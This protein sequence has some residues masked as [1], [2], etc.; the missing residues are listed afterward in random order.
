MI[1]LLKIPSTFFKDEYFLV[2][3]DDLTN[4]LGS[5]VGVIDYSGRC[6]WWMK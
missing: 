4:F 6:L 1:K 2:N 5:I 3:R